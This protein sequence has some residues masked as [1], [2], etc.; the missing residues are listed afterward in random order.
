MVVEGPLLDSVRFQMMMIMS[1]LV[2]YWSIPGM[3]GVLKSPVWCLNLHYKV[4]FDIGIV[5]MKSSDGHV[6]CNISVQLCVH[7]QYKYESRY[8]P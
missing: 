5:L 4:L 6:L 2:M 1:L 7:G 8:R 3:M